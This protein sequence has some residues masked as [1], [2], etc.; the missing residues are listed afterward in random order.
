LATATIDLCYRT[1]FSGKLTIIPAN[2]LS[3]P[4]PGKL[5]IE[6]RTGVLSALND[7]N[8]LFIIEHDISFKPRI[9]GVSNSE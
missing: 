3:S 2:G 9:V 6:A 7:E 1:S 8:M 5:V 4:T